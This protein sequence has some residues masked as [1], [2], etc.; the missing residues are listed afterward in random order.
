LS[1]KAV[2]LG[3]K[4]EKIEKI[5]KQFKYYA[6]VYIYAG[7]QSPLSFAVGDPLN[8]LVLW[9]RAAPGLDRPLSTRWTLALA[10]AGESLG[11][12]Q[13]NSSRS[14]WLFL[15]NSSAEEGH[16][17]HRRQMKAVRGRSESAILVGGL[18]YNL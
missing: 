3:E 14:L 4:I 13:R 16:T 17:T 12:E 10:T 7:R 2:G 8:E 9:C 5:E 18:P 6:G 1:T 11:P 15:R